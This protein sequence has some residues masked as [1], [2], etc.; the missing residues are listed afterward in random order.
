MS[1]KALT[2]KTKSC[3]LVSNIIRNLDLK[4]QWMIKKPDALHID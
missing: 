4:S 2:V 3:M 1:S